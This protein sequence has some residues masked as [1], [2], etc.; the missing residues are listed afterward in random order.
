[1]EAKKVVIDSDLI[2]KHLRTRDKKDTLFQR[3]L[4]KYECY[5]TFITEYEIYIGAKSPSQKEDADKLFKVIKILPTVKGC[6]K[7][8]AQKHQEIKAKGLE[9]GIMDALIAGIC[10]FN[11]T[12]L[13]TENL[14]H[15]SRFGNLHLIR[16]KD[17]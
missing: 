4:N 16:T 2:I 12:P 1:M 15:F 3:V 8:A 11:K 14:E 9:V 6:A 13:L 5:A 7:I 10:I 17:I